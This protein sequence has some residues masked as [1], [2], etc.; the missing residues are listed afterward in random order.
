MASL[1]VLR[2]FRTYLALD[3]SANTRLPEVPL[4]TYRSR[5]RTRRLVEAEAV[6]GVVREEEVAAA[7]VAKVEKAVVVIAGGKEVAIAAEPFEING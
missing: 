4:Q 7:K 2:C 5:T 1:Y 3:A 6:R